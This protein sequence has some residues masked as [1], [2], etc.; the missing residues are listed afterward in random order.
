MNKFWG[1]VDIMFNGFLL[2]MGFSLG[3]S[4]IYWA[5]IWLN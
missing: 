3:L 2:G 1:Y 4:I 5:A